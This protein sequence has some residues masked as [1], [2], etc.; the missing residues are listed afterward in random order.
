MISRRLATQ[1]IILLI[2]CLALAIVIFPY[3]WTL[4]ASFKTEAAL[5]RPLD[6]NF[7]PTLANWQAMLHSE[8]PRQV[9]NS[10]IVGAVTVLLSL[11]LGAPAAYSFSR[12]R[13]GGDGARFAVLLAQMLPPAAL[14]VPLF[15]L[16]YTL[17][18][19]DTL[20]AV[21]ASHLT[22]ILPLVTWF[23]IGFFDDVPPELEEQAMV[24]GCTQW[25]A[26]YR[27]VLPTIRP[28]LGAAALFGFVLSWNDLFY[29]LL[30]TGKHSRTLPVGIAGYWTFRG[31]E[32]GQMSAAIILAIGPVIIAS[33]FVQ[34]YL[35][36]GLG[37]GA[38]KG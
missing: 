13:T 5:N 26:F 6:W 24:D 36:R 21:V 9:L 31:I 23:L 4:L 37:G 32:M 14:I 1:A 7:T 10:I 19:L 25:Q 29:A 30:L 17:R 11:L 38:V 33:F 15:L 22:F 8:I 27:V 16:M 28:G 12:F 20:W 35:V 3:L 34:R 18:L 2:L